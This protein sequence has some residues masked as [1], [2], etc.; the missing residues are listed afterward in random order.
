MTRV[1]VLG[2]G[3]DAERE[4]SIASATA[5]HQGCLDA[6]LNATLLIIDRP[7]LQ[8]VQSWDTDVIFPA[9]H[10]RFGEGGGLQV[11]LEQSRHPFVGSRSQAAKLAMDKL[12]TKLIAARFTIPT[13]SA[14]VFDPTDCAFPHE[15]FC[16]LEFPVVIK[17]VADGSSVGLHIINDA[18]QWKDAIIKV[19][20]DLR[21]NP[22][23]VYMIERMVHGREL[24]VSVLAN[25][26]GDLEA[27]PIIEIAPA[28]GV[29]DY[30]A[31]YTRNDTI[32]TPN[33]DIPDHITRGIKEHAA[34]ICVALGVE[35]LARVDFLLSEDGHWVLLE[36]NTMP[37]FTRTS[38]FP[39]SAGATGF[40]MP[41]LCAHLVGC[42]LRGHTT[43]H[44]WSS[45]SASSS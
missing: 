6:G 25:E 23:R 45:S 14:A 37:G 1:L 16:P 33:P 24:T 18:R 42:A 5:I 11:L 43:S 9:L 34:F 40:A 10:G 12:A 15:S 41:K 19:G 30:N 29:Y 28:Q 31:K 3:P 2:G 4:V 27:L 36:V 35:H 17:P 13:P 21:A 32:Y 20:D 39:K 8:D 22:S 38:L 7:N 26:Y 44:K